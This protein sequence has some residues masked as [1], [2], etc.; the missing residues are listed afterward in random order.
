MKL[1]CEEESEGEGEEEEAHEE[2]KER[3][4]RG[5]GEEERGGGAEELI[6]TDWCVRGCMC[7]WRKQTTHTKKRRCVVFLIF[8]R[9]FNRGFACC[10]FFFFT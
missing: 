8:R 1:T 10:V 4:G 9:I 7:V 2:G 5:G 3:R 6:I